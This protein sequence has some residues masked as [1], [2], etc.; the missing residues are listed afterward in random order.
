MGELM[1]K[2]A[3]LL[4][5]ITILLG[6]SVAAK[7]ETRAEIVVTLPFG[8][9]I[10]GKT[11]PAGT[12][13]VSRLSAD[14]FDGVMFTSYDKHTSV[15]VR[16]SEIESA[17]PD[18]SQISFQ[19]VGDQHF[20]STIQTPSDVYHFPVSRSVIME[21]AAKSRDNASTSGSSGGN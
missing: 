18:K 10:G 21:A 6:L 16:P 13:T 15:F 7:T 2:Y 1:N 11:L 20:L 14:K 3:R 4:V 5:A 9:V 12:Y 19:R 8:F 17:P